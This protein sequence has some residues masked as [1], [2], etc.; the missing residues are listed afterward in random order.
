M[1]TYKK[2]LIGLL[3]VLSKLFYNF[4]LLKVIS[5]YLGPSG[6][7]LYS[8]FRSFCQLSSSLTNFNSS[9]YIVQRL[10]NKKNTDNF[11]INSLTLILITNFL[12]FLVIFL[13]IG[14]IANIIFLSNEEKFNEF[15]F[16]SS[17]I[18][19]LSSL[20]IFLFSS[21]NGFKFYFRYTISS[22]IISIVYIFL[23][24]YFTLYFSD[25]SLKSILQIILISETISILILI[26]FLFNKIKINNF[27][28]QKIMY[29]FIS[30]KF[31]FKNSLYF[32]ISAI[33]FFSSL[34]FL[35]TMIIKFLS[36]SDLGKFES[37]WSL[38]ILLSFICTKSFSF[39][40]LPELSDTKLKKIDS[41]INKYLI[42]S[43]LVIIFLY[44]P[45]FLI[46]KYLIPVF[47]TKDF[48]DAFFY[49]RWLIIAEVVK[50]Y[51]FIFTYP[52]IAKAQFKFFLYMEVFFPL[53]FVLLSV[54]A[55][56]YYLSIELICF[57]YVVVNILYLIASILFINIRLQYV[58]DYRNILMN[59]LPILFFFIIVYLNWNQNLNIFYNFV[60][61]FLFSTIYLF[62][63]NLK[64]QNFK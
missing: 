34:L 13:N 24:I 64:L 12:F 8:Q 7:G 18:I 20:I 43:P 54:F 45:F 30:F 22:I 32:L 1:K 62:I 41:V 14:T 48:S 25:F 2:V 4:F 42:L 59:I 9:A 28:N 38:S 16:Y 40:Y 15:I 37:A 46:S 5:I 57:S 56:K 52:I 23:T 3:N 53:I 39:Y 60:I 21:L 29:I 51:I 11:F 26:S 49:L 17:F 58:F 44:T 35:K 19:P 31:F 6:I 55:L 10:S 47:F 61:F 50:F 33:V 27:F 36:F 63:F